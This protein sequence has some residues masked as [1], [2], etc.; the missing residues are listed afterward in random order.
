VGG[1]HAAC[2]CPAAANVAIV[3]ASISACR[4]QTGLGPAPRVVAR[5]PDVSPMLARANTL[6]ATSVRY[7]SSSDVVLRES[8][9][10]R[11]NRRVDKMP[12][13]GSATQM[14]PE[15]CTTATVIDPIFRHAPRH[16]EPTGRASARPMTGSAKQSIARAVIASAA[17]Q[18]IAP[19]QERMDCFAPLAMT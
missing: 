8:S 6:K 16:C 13:S 3:T 5:T 18:S 1:S 14:I 4:R 11:V 15:R 7:D 10:A 19:Q 12:N 17:K 9:D 2:A